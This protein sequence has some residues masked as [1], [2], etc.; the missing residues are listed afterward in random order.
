VSKVT[1]LERDS[2][3][4]YTAVIKHA[5]QLSATRKNSLAHRAATDQP[6]ALQI[7]TCI[8]DYVKTLFIFL[9]QQTKPKADDVNTLFV[10][11]SNIADDVNTLVIFLI[12]KQQ[13]PTTA[14]NGDLTALDH[15]KGT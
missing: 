3:Y 4:Q 7:Q 11:L 5:F 8:T 13:F 2:T 12:Q 10:F 15:P 14:S 1:S 6:K 9:M